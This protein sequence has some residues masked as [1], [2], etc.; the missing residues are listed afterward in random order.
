MQSRSLKA[1][2]E[3]PSSRKPWVSRPAPQ[4]SGREGSEAALERGQFWVCQR[5]SSRSIRLR[6]LTAR[7]SPWQSCTSTPPGLRA[8]LPMHLFPA[9]I[10]SVTS[11]GRPPPSSSTSATTPA[12]MVHSKSCGLPALGRREK[13]DSIASNSMCPDAAMAA[14]LSVPRA[15]VPLRAWMRFTAPNHSLFAQ[16]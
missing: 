2:R 11:L 6:A 14:R 5:I 1:V 15:T 9:P 7:I 16:A 12:A 8:P 10:V 4:H 3:V 13:V